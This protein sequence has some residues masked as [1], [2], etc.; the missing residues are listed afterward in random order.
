MA[1]VTAVGVVASAAIHGEQRRRRCLIFLGEATNAFPTTP[2]SCGLPSVH[3]MK[4]QTDDRKHTRHRR[5]ANTEKIQS[6]QLS[7]QTRHTERSTNSPSSQSTT[8]PT[9]ASNPKQAHIGRPTTLST[10]RT[11]TQISNRRRI[12]NRC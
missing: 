9:A 4:K 10:R 2:A 8:A 11:F 3:Q 12:E 6:T 5:T 7:T 1:G